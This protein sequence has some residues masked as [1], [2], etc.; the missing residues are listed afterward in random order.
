MAKLVYAIDSKSVTCESVRVR[1]PFRAP[2]NEHRFDTMISVSIKL[3]FV[4]I[5]AKNPFPPVSKRSE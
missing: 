5:K 3:F 1:L 2:Y 4:G